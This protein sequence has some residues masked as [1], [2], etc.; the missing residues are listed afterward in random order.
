MTGS[1]VRLLGLGD[2]TVDIYVDRNVMFPGGNAVNV[3]VLAKRLGADTGYLGC[4]ANDVFGRLLHDSMSA[5]G[6]D[7]SR[8]RCVDGENA[9]VQVRH[10]DGDRVFV[11]STP[12]VR[13]AYRLDA[14]D[15][16]YVR[17]FDAVHSSYC[18]DNEEMI[19]AIAE[20]AGLLS[21][22]FSYRWSGDL[23]ARI[24]PH[25]DIAFLSFPDHDEAE[26]LAVLRRWS[27]AGPRVVVMTRGSDGALAWADGAMHRQKIVPAPVVDTL[28]AGDAFIA[29]FLI[30]YLRDRAIRP[31][32]QN[33]AQAAAAACGWLGGFGHGVPIAGLP[34]EDLP[35]PHS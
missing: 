7:L 30:R 8:C 22:D 32:L 9:H 26:C 10:R 27:S 4:L 6:V 14:D 28:G 34:P 3:A 19:P 20:A 23:G 24:A 29:G 25:V 15:F 21:Y 18:S 5:E 11:K 1:S 12:G 17:S 35:N 31:A 33:G 13:A 2:N 16:A